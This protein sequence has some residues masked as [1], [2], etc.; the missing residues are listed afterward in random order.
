M[1]R[2][3]TTRE[4]NYEFFC[5]YLWCLL[6]LWILDKVCLHFDSMDMITTGLSFIYYYSIRY[7][8]QVP[9]I[10]TNQ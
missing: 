4:K 10:V 7:F 8:Y 6:L 3:S 1:S 2:Q 9:S 5:G